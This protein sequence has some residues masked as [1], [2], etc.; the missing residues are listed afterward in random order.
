MTSPRFQSLKKA[1]F[2]RSTTLAQE[3][4]TLFLKWWKLL[5]KPLENQL[6]SLLLFVNVC[7]FVK[8]LCESFSYFLVSNLT[9]KWYDYLY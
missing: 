4:D 2:S 8:F 9:L 3:E 1:F 5:K 7:S 6:V